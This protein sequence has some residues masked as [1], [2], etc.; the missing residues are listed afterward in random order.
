MAVAS[1]HLAP[2]LLTVAVLFSGAVVVDA[3]AANTVLPAAPPTPFAISGNLNLPLYPG[4]RGPLDLTLTNSNAQAMAVTGLA[5][6]VT[7][8]QALH[9]GPLQPCDVA[10]FAV[11]QFSGEFPINVAASSARSLS[12]LGIPT[13][14]MP[15]LRMLDTAGNQDGCK[16][17]TLTLAYT[18]TAEESR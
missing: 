15:V 14:A 9:P 17:A 10:D 18:G 5:A 16:H 4:G 11:D 2:V 12:D 1:N 13:S 6:T 7:A 8:V 3:L